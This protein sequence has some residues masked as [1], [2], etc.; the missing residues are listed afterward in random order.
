MQFDQASRERERASVQ[1]SSCRAL[2]V[3]FVAIELYFE[4]VVDTNSPVC[5]LWPI[6]KFSFKFRECLFLKSR[7][8]NAFCRHG[9][10][11]V[12]GHILAPLAYFPSGNI[13][14]SERNCPPP[15]F[16]RMSRQSASAYNL[17]H[18]RYPYQLNDTRVP[19][20][21]SI[22]LCLVPYAE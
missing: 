7:R 16:P 11:H 20:T 9:V 21:L 17:A 6:L 14:S 5:S 3:L 18:Y 22:P 19:C 10:P 1:A 2:V 12:V 15:P 4:H 13:V 8:I